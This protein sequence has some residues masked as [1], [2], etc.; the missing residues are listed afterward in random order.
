MR[1]LS[2]LFANNLAW[3]AE[4][5]HIPVVRLFYAQHLVAFLLSIPV[6][7]ALGAKLK[8]PRWLQF[9]SAG[10][11]AVGFWARFVLETD[12]GYEISAIPVVLLFVLAW[13]LLTESTRPGWLR[14]EHVLLGLAGAAVVVSYTSSL[15]LCALAVIIYE[16]L[17]LLQSGPR[18]KAWL[19]YVTAS[20]VVVGAL[21]FTGQLDF[22]A[23]GTYWFIATASGEAQ[24]EPLVIEAF[25][26]DG[27]AGLWG[28]SGPLIATFGPGYL[29]R[30]IQV[31][32]QALGV[33]LSGAWLVT[34]LM[35]L[36]RSA[37]KPERI[38]FC[39]VGIAKG[40]TQ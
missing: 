3:A 16:L 35:S 1:F 21:A 9:L 23:Y 11:I 19:D 27:I 34:G 4:M 24:Y 36:K 37:P 20:G 31:L 40:K 26:R 2:N 18:P 6:V 7:V 33:A 39:M 12:A 13:M 14:R 5:T 22:I 25:K 10:A 32:V 8:L 38:V 29:R 28:L 15:V 17:A 30:L